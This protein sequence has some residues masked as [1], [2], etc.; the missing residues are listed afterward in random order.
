MI[1]YPVVPDLTDNL[2]AYIYFGNSYMIGQSPLNTKF[3]T[4]NLRKHLTNHLDMP[5]LL[6]NQTDSG[7]LSV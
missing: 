1:L 3:N 2:R 7:L 4:G 6:H 5:S